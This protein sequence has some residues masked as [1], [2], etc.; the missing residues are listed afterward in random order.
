MAT[1]TAK[2]KPRGPRVS[3]EFGNAGS[4]KAQKDGTKE[5][6]MMLE[7]TMKAFG[8]KQA[9]DS[10]LTRTSKK[11]KRSVTVRGSVGAGSI[12][13]PTGK[14]TKKKTDQLLSIPVPG[15][16][17]LQQIK[18]FLRRAGKRP[19]YFISVDGRKHSLNAR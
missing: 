19:K 7:S 10:A 5:Y 9:Q 18:T 8:F 1:T 15:N 12:K 16:A 2:R 14:K 13:V 17:T 6:V 3:V 11:S 4:K